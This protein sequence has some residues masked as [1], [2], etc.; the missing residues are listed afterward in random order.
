V[1]QSNGYVLFKNS[2]VAVIATG[3]RRASANSKT[4]KMV[5]IWILRS[6]MNPLEAIAT[7][8]DKRICG[9]CPH[10]GI[11]GQRARTC[12][13]RIGRAPK[14]IYKAFRRG[15]Y[16]FLKLEDYASIFTGK[17][18]RFGA[19]GDPAVIP[20]AIVAELAKFASRHTGYTHQWRTSDWLRPFVMASCDTLADYAEATARGWRTFRVS[21]GQTPQLGEILCPASAEAGARTQCARCGLCNG[22]RAGVKNIY[23]PVHGASKKSAF[24]ILQ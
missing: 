13:V 4:G 7:G 24:T 18:I 23:I 20:Q 16:P 10:R 11:K 5:Q 21:I 1:I 19:Y 22:A 2:T 15:R 6:D 3:I 17:A 14:P 8:K 9:T 12:Y